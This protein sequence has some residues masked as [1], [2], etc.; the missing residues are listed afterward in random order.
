MMHPTC[1]FR[2]RYCTS[3]KVRSDIYCA[4]R[5]RSSERQ[6]CR[7]TVPCTEERIGI[8]RSVKYE[9]GRA[10]PDPRET[11]GQ[12]GVVSR[13]DFRTQVCKPCRFAGKLHCRILASRHK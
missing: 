3:A 13:Y 8:S 9:V 5:L 2:P 6:Q 4:V 10:K 12:M 11:L 1:R 7:T